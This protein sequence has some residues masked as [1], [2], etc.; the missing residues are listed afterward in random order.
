V[1]GIVAVRGRDTGVLAADLLDL[2]RHRGPDGSGLLELDG[3][4]L[5]M[6]R[7]AILD[8]TDRAN[9]PMSYEGRHL[10]YNGEIYN[11][12]ALRSELEAA[13]T[14]FVTTGDTEVLQAKNRH[15]NNRV[16]LHEGK[17]CDRSDGEQTDRDHERPTVF[18]L[19]A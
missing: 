11:F 18:D 5:A 17:S 7:L 9:Q 14:S 3:C 12:R 8:P 15:G 1:C 19:A 4:S 2:I 13:G 10:V 16:R 6:A